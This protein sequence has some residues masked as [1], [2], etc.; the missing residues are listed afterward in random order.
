MITHESVYRICYQNTD[1]CIQCSGIWLQVE[2]LSYISWYSFWVINIWV[3]IPLYNVIL[4]IKLPKYQKVPHLNVYFHCCQF[5]CISKTSFSRSFNFFFLFLFEACSA[6]NIYCNSC[7]PYF[8]FCNLANKDILSVSG[9]NVYNKQHDWLPSNLLN[10]LNGL[11]FN[12]FNYQLK[13]I[14]RNL[15]QLFS[16]ISFT[17]LISTVF[18]IIHVFSQWSSSVRG[19]Q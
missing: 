6:F 14:Y 8:T 11:L 15:R 18:Q 1:G 17:C 4:N 19:D 12:K 16:Q 13:L 7:L 5:F 3:L 2:N 9:E 10:G